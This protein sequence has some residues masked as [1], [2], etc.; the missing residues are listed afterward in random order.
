MER[1]NSKN[2]PFFTEYRLRNTLTGPYVESEYQDEYLKMTHEVLIFRRSKFGELADFQ[3]PG[4][5]MV[6]AKKSVFTKAW[7]QPRILHIS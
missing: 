1:K 3:E 6:L 7:R 4:Q 5:I 2:K